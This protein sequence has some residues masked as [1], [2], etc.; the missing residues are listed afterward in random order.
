MRQYS[1]AR[2]PQQNR[3]AERRNR[4]LIEAARIKLADSKLPT[5]F[6]AEAVNNVC[7]VQNKTANSPFSS[8][9]KSYQDTEFQLLNDGTKRVD[10]NLS[11]ENEFN[12]Q[13]E[14]DSTN[15]TNK[16]NIVTLNTNA[17][18]SSGVNA[19]GTNISINL[20]PDLHMPLLEDIG[21]FEDSHDDKDVF[22]A[23][24]Y[25]HNLDSTFQVSH[26]P[27]TR[28]HKDH[29]LKKVIGYLHSTPQTRR[30]TNNLEEH[31][32]V[33]TVIPRTDNKNL[34]NCLFACFLSKMEPKKVLQALKDPSWIE[35][36]QEELLQLKLQ[37]DEGIDY[38]E[39]FAPVARIDAIRLFMAYASFKDFIVYQMDVKSVFLYGKIEE[40]VYVCQTPKVYKVEKAHY[41]LHQ[42]PRACVARTPQQNRVAE[43]RNR[44][45][46]EA[47]RTK[48]A[49]SKLP[50]TF[51]AEAVNTVCYVQ[52]K[53]EDS[54]N[55]TNKLNIVTLNTNAASS[56]GVNAVG[57]N[58]SINLPP[59]LHMPLLEDIGIFEDSHDDEDVFGAEAYF[60]NLDSTFQVNHIPI[61][62]I[63]KDHSLKKIVDFLNANQIKYALMVSPTIY[64][65]CIKQFYTTVKIKTI[66]DDVWLQ[67]LIDGKK[68]VI[69][70]A[71]IRHDLKLNDAEDTPILNAP[72]S[73]QP[74]RKHE[75]R[76]K[77]KKETEVSPTKINTDDHVPTTSNDPLP[78]GKDRMQ[79][80]ELKDLCTNLSNK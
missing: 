36:M 48:L 40:E 19:V 28:I 67:A 45:L 79:L 53:E 39:V 16:V 47:A 27:I 11:N 17:A 68:V 80:K 33:G 58:I 63:H 70:E 69:N 7:Y 9:S 49:D 23:E 44:T 75:P 65:S 15:S 6:W 12:D 4:T 46:I 59:D 61:T 71:S 37:D 73:S 56:S 13:W 38:D 2:T 14:E 76:K 1:V 29:P 5:T 30:M 72:S 52:N 31:G 8:T 51:W 35:A 64:T 18:S 24:A 22:G 74:Q 55:S 66:N 43:R 57:T 20:P 21:I 54:T 25:F 50:T 34:Q 26:I 32:L 42:A 62:R 77:E 10:E 41:G 60:H 3:V 78:S